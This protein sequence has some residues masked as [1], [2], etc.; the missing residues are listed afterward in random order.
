MAATAKRGEEFNRLLAEQG[1]VTRSMKYGYRPDDEAKAA[2]DA[3]AA[4]LVE[5]AELFGPAILG[6]LT[7]E[8]YVNDRIATWVTANPLALTTQ[9]VQELIEG[10]PRPPHVSASVRTVRAK[11]GTPGSGGYLYQFTAD[12]VAITDGG[13]FELVIPDSVAEHFRQQGRREIQRQFAD[14]LALKSHL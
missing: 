11:I 9:R 5:L 6:D 10:P 7:P 3:R 12:D 13:A 14:L 2:I 1:F 4:R 8:R